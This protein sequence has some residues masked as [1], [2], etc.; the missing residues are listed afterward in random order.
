MGSSVVPAQQPVGE[1]WQV[2]SSVTASGTTVSFT[3]ISGYRKLKIIGAP[4]TS[5]T[6]GSM[7]VRFNSDSGAKYSF[8]KDGAAPAIRETSVSYSALGNT[9]SLVLTVDNINT[10]GNKTMDGYFSTTGGSFPAYTQMLLGDYET[11][12]AITSIQLTTFSTFNSGNVTLFGV[13]L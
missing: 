8:I 13:A 5:S 9:H 7:L 1:N 6:G 3:S 2:I 10:T 11:T 12:S 4:V